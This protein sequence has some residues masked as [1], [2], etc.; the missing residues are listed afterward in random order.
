M[1]KVI[2]LA[3][4]GAANAGGSDL[5]N[6]CIDTTSAQSKQPWCNSSLPIDDRVKDMIGAHLPS[7]PPTALSHCCL[8]H[9]LCPLQAV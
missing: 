1:S 8:S 2:I 9:H 5:N 3:L 4:V 6:P 7:D